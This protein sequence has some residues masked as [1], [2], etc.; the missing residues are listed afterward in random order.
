MRIL[1]SYNRS[2]QRNRYAPSFGLAVRCVRKLNKDIPVLKTVK[3]FSEK[4]TFPEGIQS[5]GYGYRR[6]A[7]MGFVNRGKNSNWWS[8]SSSG[9]GVWNRE[10]NFGYRSINRNLPARYYG[11]SVR[12]VRNEWNICR[13]RTN[14]GL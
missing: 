6:E 8:A 4:V 1:N 14:Q 2:V 9:T 11:M 13:S 12:C 10:L 7:G 3:G 5:V